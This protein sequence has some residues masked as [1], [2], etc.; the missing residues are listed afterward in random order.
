MNECAPSLLAADAVTFSTTGKR[1]WHIS[2][3]NSKEG[4]SNGTRNALLL[5]EKTIELAASLSAFL[6]VLPLT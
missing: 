3:I 6:T 5:F 1:K 2:P 4:A